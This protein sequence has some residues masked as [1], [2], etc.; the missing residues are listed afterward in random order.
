MLV[1]IIAVAVAAWAGAFPNSPR[2]GNALSDLK[3]DAASKGPDKNGY[4]LAFLSMLYAWEGYDQ[5]KYVRV[6]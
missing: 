5:P 1:F 3:N 4:V 6:G 2:A